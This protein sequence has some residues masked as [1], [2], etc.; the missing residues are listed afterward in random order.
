MITWLGWLGWLLW[1][2]SKFL[3]DY[4]YSYHYPFR[5]NVG[6]QRKEAGSQPLA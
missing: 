6:L 5:V 4:L 2:L 3:Y 1:L